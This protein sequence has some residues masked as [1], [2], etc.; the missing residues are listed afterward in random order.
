MAKITLTINGLPV[1][2]EEGMTIL[3]AAQGAGIY[4]PTLCHHPDL[5]T[6]GVCRICVVDIKGQKLLQPAC[7]FPVSD[8]MSVMT[9]SPRVRQARK[10]IIELLLANHPQDC[11]T[12][13]K[14]Q[15]CELQKLSKE[16]GIEDVPFRGERKV[17]DEDDSSASVIRDPEKCI[18]CKR[19]IRVCHEI[20]SVGTLSASGRGWDMTIGPALGKTM[21]EAVCVNCGQCI[22]RC[23]T[24]ALREKSSVQQVWAALHDPAKHVVVQTAPA[25]R[26]A[27]GEEFGM[28]PGH[29]VTGKMVTALRAMGFDKVFD[30]DFTAD[31]T[32]MEEG[33][34]LIHRI[35]NSGVLPQLTSCSPGWIKFIEHFYPELL[36]HV[37]S[38]K[39]PQ[40]MF[41][42]LAKTY[43]AEKAGIDPKDIVSVSIMPCAAKKYECDRPEMADS[44]YKDVDY[45]LTTREA[46]AM[47]K[48]AGIEL[49]NLP[50]G[51]YD[52]PLGE[53]TGA[54][55]IFG[56]TGGVMEAAIRTAYAVLTGSELDNV[57]IT[58]VRGMDGVRSAEIPVAGIALKAAVAHGLGNAR[59][60]LEGIKSGKFAD[61]HF[62]EIMCCPG[63][64]I[65]G[66]GQPIPTNEEIR[67]KRA[68]AIYEE[69][70]AMTV[71]R[72]HENPS[73][74]KLYK[75]FLGEPLSHK[76]H[77]L[78]HTHY[79]AR[80]MKPD[81][82]PE[83]KPVKVKID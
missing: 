52:D 79:T 50:D 55:V 27:I 21:V 15:K 14:N 61:Y 64:C 76:S 56:N 28:E 60:V 62:I 67:K 29:R 75:E 18:M 58:A 32:I 7:A 82:K 73:V 12:C 72:S 81:P 69:D 26:A 8:G 68:Q 49:P 16:Y 30:T 34:E 54:A 80:G 20:Q 36:P 45:V 33:Y 42:A 44:G 38:C 3:Q 74:Q 25:V 40:Q 39:S 57:N 19:C 1:V 17:Y 31:L 22:N 77:E 23:P 11:L 83:E 2:A 6:E 71:R 48:E 66:G 78:L 47:M 4:I 65:G 63:G 35:K 5:R 59:E 37:S 70:E 53:S 43:Y 46:A 10:M 13:S 51:Q 41:G 9:H 24:G